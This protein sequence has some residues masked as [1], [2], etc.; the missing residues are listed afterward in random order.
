VKIFPAKLHGPGYL[1]ELKAPLPDAPLIAV[2]GVDTTTAPQYLAAGAF[3]VGLGS[4][5]L[6]DA[7]TGG[8]QSGLAARASTFL[9]AVADA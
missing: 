2:G 1:R 3:A 7:G 5:L 9:A 4:P 8:S 6:G